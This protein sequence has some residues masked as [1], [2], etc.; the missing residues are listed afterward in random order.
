[1]GLYLRNGVWYSRWYQGG[2]LQ[3][4]S[5]G[6]GDRAEA[7]SMYR[8]IT[9]RPL[10]RRTKQ[11]RRR[12]ALATFD[13]KQPPKIFGDLCDRWGQY[14]VHGHSHLKRSSIDAYMVQVRRFREMW[15]TLL[16]SG[17]TERHIEEWCESRNNHYSNSTLKA[18]RQ[19]L[20]VFLRWAHRR[21]YIERVPE[22]PRTHGVPKKLPRPLSESEIEALFDTISKHPMPQV[23]ALK[24]FAMVCLHAG[25][26]REEARFLTWED[27]DLDVRELRVT[28]KP[29]MFSIKDHEERS[30]SLNEQFYEYLVGL[31]RE[32]PDAEPWVC[33]NE[34]FAQWSLGVSRWLRVLFDDAGVGTRS[35]TSH[36]FRHT[37]A[38]TLLRAGVDLA[39]LRDLMG[40][41]DISVTSRYLAATPQRELTPS[42]A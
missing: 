13:S 8:R 29:P 39:T 19:V 14:L 3:R 42:S 9:G 41:S 35:G 38:T 1:M 18:E 20:R 4:R 40:H 33:V 23:R 5:L 26:R 28:N 37:F 27:L 15:G 10:N 31:R 6:T 24:P 17:L 25:L 2:R 12:I 36:R 22:I 21:E 11:Q 34:R 32:R 16:V 30:I 7:E